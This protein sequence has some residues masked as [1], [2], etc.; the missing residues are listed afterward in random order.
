[1]ALQVLI[2]TRKHSSYVRTRVSRSS[3][4]WT[5][6][7]IFPVDPARTVVTIVRE[8]GSDAKL[9]QLLAAPVLAE[10]VGLSAGLASTTASRPERMR[11]SRA[12]SSRTLRGS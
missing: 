11:R 4:P 5:I 6:L 10:L 2:M 7:S 3:S 8:I 12:S 9:K 1:M